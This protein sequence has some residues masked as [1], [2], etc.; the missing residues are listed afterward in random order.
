M[1]EPT[2]PAPVRTRR[3]L[4]ISGFDPA[5]PGRYHALYREQAARQDRH[6]GLGIAVG[7]RSTAVPDVVSW[8]VR[9]IAGGEPIAGE[10]VAIT[11]DFLRYDNIM[12]RHWARGDAAL[13]GQIA[14]TAWRTLVNGQWLA[15]LRT[16][17]PI[18][19][20][21]TVPTVL[22]LV[23][24]LIAAVVPL[25]P[26]L[27]GAPWWAPALAYPPC[28][29]GAWWLRRRVEARTHPFWIAR[30]THF[31]ALQALGRIPGLEE[32]LD[33]FADLIAAAAADPGQDEVLVVGHSIGSQLA[34]S[35][36]A[37]ALPR[38]D[39]AALGRLSLLT[40]GQTLPL[41]GLHP[42]AAA[43]RAEVASLKA[44]PGL[45]WIDFSA[46]PDPACFPL[47]DPGRAIGLPPSGA[48]ARPKL[49]NPHFARLFDASRYADAKH[50]WHAMH[51][52]YLMASDHKGDYDYFAITAGR[53]S[54]G[55]RF[56]ALDSAENFDRF[57]LF[58]TWPVSPRLTRSHPRRNTMP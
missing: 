15:V 25:L 55:D 10:A 58:K 9:A 8:T 45:T 6:N 35:A 40:L 29:A 3:V 32:R 42:A 7:P 27:F 33:R 14:A 46:P 43:F 41:L 22:A 19:I 49:V 26:V 18:G 36:V 21:I 57:R 38:L 31:T 11:Y 1:P 54:L 17:W 34:A 23:L 2:P 37:R 30:I 24:V 4:Y 5:G 48:A 12:R 20:T 39:A 28:I 51:F 47:T 16:S 52:Q 50:D 13:L 56:Q 53:L 44:C